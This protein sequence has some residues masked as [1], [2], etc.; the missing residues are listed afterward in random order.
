MRKS[1]AIIISKGIK[2]LR[3]NFGLAEK[4]RFITI[5]RQEPKDYTERRRELLAGKTFDEIYNLADSQ[6]K[7]GNDK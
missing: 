6:E 2:T 4:K 1:A 5:I 3:E 7:A